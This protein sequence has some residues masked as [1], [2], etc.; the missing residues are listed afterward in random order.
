M[1]GCPHFPVSV[2][3]LC[4]KLLTHCSPAPPTKQEEQS[5]LCPE[6]VCGLAVGGVPM[7]VSPGGNHSGWDTCSAMSLR[8]TLLSLPGLTCG[9]E[10]S[11]P[12]FPPSFPGF[13]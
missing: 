7:C 11:N 10:A 12:S 3:G 1:R 5:G 9:N 2:R 6:G 13:T 8:G 4:K